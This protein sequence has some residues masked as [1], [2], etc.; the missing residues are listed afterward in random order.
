MQL[1]LRA[2][3]SRRGD[4][5]RV[6]LVGPDRKALLQNDGELIAALQFLLN[7]MGRRAWP[8][9]GHVQLDCDGYKHTRE[10]SVVEL[11]REVAS[12][13]ARTGQPKRLHPMNPFERRLVH[14]TV[15]EFSGLTS[16][17]DGDGFLKQITVEAA[18]KDRYP[19]DG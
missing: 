19:G 9:A 13:V 16:R 15:Q 8:H 3:V 11:A 2:R 6:E 14:M 4:G 18:G 1:D 17:S 5:C 12:V 10:E 7:R